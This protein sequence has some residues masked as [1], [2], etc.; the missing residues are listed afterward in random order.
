MRLGILAFV[1]AISVG[2]HPSFS[3]SES[4]ATVT[5]DAS[6]STGTFHT[7]LTTQLGYINAPD[8]S[9]SYF[10]KLAPASPIRIHMTSEESDHNLLPEKH[11]NQWDLK[12]LDSF[13]NEITSWG[14]KA[15]LNVKFPPDF[16]WS[17]KT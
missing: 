14:G 4:T 11:S 9:V 12:P 6:Q 7:V 10:A 17:C 15:M 3:L 8:A 13:V 2:G 1:W 5:V 16:M